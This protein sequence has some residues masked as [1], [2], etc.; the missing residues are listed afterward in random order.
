MTMVKQ[1]KPQNKANKAQSREQNNNQPDHNGGD[2]PCGGRQPLNT[3]A[4]PPNPPSSIIFEVAE[5]VKNETMQLRKLSKMKQCNDEHYPVWW[6]WQRD[7]R[8]KYRKIEDAQPKD[9][10]GQLGEKK[11]Q[12]C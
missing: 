3:A 6:A 12:E 11:G 8:H 9:E 7:P 5:V 10:K 2:L 1:K 4:D